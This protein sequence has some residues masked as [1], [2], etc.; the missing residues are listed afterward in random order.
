MPPNG[1]SDLHFDTANHTLT[2]FVNK[3]I[4]VGRN[5]ISEELVH[6]EEPI[7]LAKLDAMRMNRQWNSTAANQTVK[8]AINKR[9][10]FR[11]FSSSNIAECAEGKVSTADSPCSKNSTNNLLSVQHN[12]TDLKSHR[13]TG[14]E[15][16]EVRNASVKLSEHDIF[17]REEPLTLAKLNEIR[18]NISV[19]NSDSVDSANL[20]EHKIAKREVF[21]PFSSSAVPECAEGQVT[22]ADVPCKKNIGTDDLLRKNITDHQGQNV[23]KGII[24]LMSEQPN[25][26]GNTIKSKNGTNVI[27]SHNDS[28][29]NVNKSADKET[30]NKTPSF[31]T[32][33]AQFPYC[34]E[35]QESTPEKPCTQ[36]NGTEAIII[37]HQ[38]KSQQQFLSHGLS[39]SFPHFSYSDAIFGSNN[40]PAVKHV[41]LADRPDI[42]EASGKYTTDESGQ[43]ME[44]LTDSSDSGMD[45]IRARV[46]NTASTTASVFRPHQSNSNI[47][48]FIQNPISP[49]S[50]VQPESAN[51]SVLPASPGIIN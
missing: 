37:A 29:R 10:A 46:N 20:T 44:I 11:S 31:E 4:T 15:N 3:N 34:K 26:T 49:L 5:N 42:L 50:G 35:G 48:R 9:E 25:I 30:K 19:S 17:R 21:W 40:E 18:Y 23:T 2:N 27:I 45:A 38:G 24:V 16:T 41:R 36:V 1:K 6:R 8:H 32:V 33:L 51:R 22:T 47:T 14:L 12:L 7:T 13:R 39:I 43:K 28:K